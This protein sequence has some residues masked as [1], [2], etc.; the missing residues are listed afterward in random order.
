MIKDNEPDLDGRTQVNL[1]RRNALRSAAALS[2]ATVLLGAGA[3]AASASSLMNSGARTTPLPLNQRRGLGG[4]DVASI[5]LGCQWVAGPDKEI[6]NDFYGTRIDRKTASTLIR[7]A[8]DHGVTLIDTAEGYGPFASESVVGEALQGIRDKVVLETKFGWNIDL[9]T[10][11][12]LGGLNS[13]PEHIKLV[14]ERMLRRLKTDRID[15]LYQHRVDPD[16]PI[17]DVAGAVKDLIVE[18][19]VLHFGLSEPGART[20]RRAHAVQPLSAIQNEY[21]M[22]CREPEAEILPICEELGIGFVCWSPLGMGFLAGAV[23]GDSRFAGEPADFRAMVPCFAPGALKANMT[24]LNIIKKWAQRKE[25]TPA[26]I[27]LA[28][29]LAQKPWIVPVPGTTKISHMKENIEAAS[30]TFSPDELLQ[31]NAELA[32][33]H[34]QGERLPQGVLGFSNVDAPPKI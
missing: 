27:S 28:W 12:P 32:V 5:G 20:I 29:L 21:S 17:E 14:V 33:F 6:A 34:R 23:N 26:Q 13:R 30:I 25:A 22:L 1:P 15:L 24:L 19:K 16:V 18:G 2:L 3:S 10:G 31:I 4:L 9:E 7:S 8:V 11:K